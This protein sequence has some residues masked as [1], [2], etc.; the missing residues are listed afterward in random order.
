MIGVVDKLSLRQEILL[1]SRN[2]ANKKKTSLWC[3][4]EKMRSSDFLILLTPPFRKAMNKGMRFYILPS[5]IIILFN[6]DKYL[7]THYGCS[8]GVRTLYW[9]MLLVH[10]PYRNFMHWLFY[11]A[12]HHGII[13]ISLSLSSS[14]SSFRY[15]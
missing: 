13:I 14:S 10:S 4:Q 5:C 6:N 15:L 9:W 12:T 11:F 8:Y 2:N 1:T 3:V 7:W